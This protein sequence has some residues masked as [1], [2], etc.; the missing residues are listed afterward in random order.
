MENTKLVCTM[1][2]SVKMGHSGQKT[3]RPDKKQDHWQ[4]YLEL[5]WVPLKN[6]SLWNTP[7]FHAAAV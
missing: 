1:Q 6:T 7:Y 5:L 4:P 2:M 3:E